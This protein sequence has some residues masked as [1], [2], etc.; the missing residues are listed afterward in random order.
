[1]AQ[2]VK[3]R[4]LKGTN[5]NRKL[6]KPG[7]V[8]TAS[9]VDAVLL[10]GQGQAERYEEAEPPKPAKLTDSAGKPIQTR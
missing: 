7:D 3:I 5:V 6:V 10:I 9:Q 4:I 2:P 8:V 1:M